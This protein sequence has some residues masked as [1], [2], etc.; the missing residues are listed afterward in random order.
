MSLKCSNY[1]PMSADSIP[2]GE[3]CPVAGTPFEFTSGFSQ[4]ADRERLTGAIDG[5]GKPG[6]DHAFLVDRD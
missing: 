6:I 1:L 2:S 5:G 3:I 4:I